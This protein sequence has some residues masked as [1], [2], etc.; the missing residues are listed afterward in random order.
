MK[1]LAILAVLVLGIA[2][3]AYAKSPKAYQVTGKVIEVTDTL[4]VVE[5]GNAEK[6]ELTLTPETKYK[7]TMKVGSKVTIEYKMIATNAEVKEDKPGDKGTEKG[8]GEKGE[9]GEKG[10]GGEH[11]EK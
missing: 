9:K 8:K 2:A 5:K 1:R 6:W 4:V 7:G 11:H 3:V 10:K